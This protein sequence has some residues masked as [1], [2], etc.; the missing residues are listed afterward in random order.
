M[1][2]ISHPLTYLSSSL[3]LDETYREAPNLADVISG[4]LGKENELVKR[5]RKFRN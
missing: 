3:E 2:L 4:L 5:M 1:M